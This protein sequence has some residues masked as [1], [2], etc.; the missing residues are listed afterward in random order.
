MREIASVC[1]DNNGFIWA[2][3]KTGILRLTED[4]YHVYQLPLETADILT[5][6][7]IYKNSRLFAYSNNGQLF[8]Y[9][10]LY[11]RFDFLFDIRKPLKDV[12]L[13]LH[14]IEIDGHGVFWLSVSSGLFKYQDGHL[15]PIIKDSDIFYLTWKDYDN[16]IYSQDDGIW[17]LNIRTLQNK[18][19]YKNTS[20]SPFQTLKLFYDR[21]TDLLW[22][23]TT[24]DGLFYY[25]FNTGIFSKTLIKT[26]PRQQIQAIECNSD[27]TL[28]FGIDGQGVWE[29]NRTG[30]R[31]LN[32]Y[33]EDVDDPS[34]L[35]GN[36]V[37]DIFCDS[38]KRVWVCT[39][40]GGLSFFEQTSPLVSQI[41]HEMNNSNS[42]NNN[43][44]NKIVEDREGNL[45]FATNNGVCRWDRLSEKWTTYYHN[46]QAQA[47][48]FLSLCEDDQGRI[49]AGAYSSGIYVIDEKTGKELAHY[50]KEEQNSAIKNDYVFDIV[51][52]REGNI[53]IGGVVGDIICYQTKENKFRTYSPQPVNAF[54]ELSDTTMLLACTYGLCLLNKRTGEEQILLEEYLS[55]D[56]LVVDSDAWICMS[57]GGLIRYDLDN[58]TTE[59][60]TVESGLPSN[61]VSSIL[62]EN[63][64]LWLS[65]EN[66]LCR[67][68]PK[69]KTTLI[70][71][72]LL[73]LSNVS[74]NRNSCCRLKNGQLAFGANTGAVLF[75]PFAIQ[76]VQ[77][78]GRIFF[79]DL[80]LS[81]RSV[82]DGSVLEL[83]APLDSLQKLALKYNQN[84]LTLEL[85]PIGTATA[86]S[87]FSWKMEGLD[88]EWS[89]PSNL[90]IL[91]YANLPIGKFALKIRLYDSSLSQLI[92]ERE[93]ALEI[94][95]PFWKTNWFRLFVFLL[96]AGIVYFSLRFYINRLKQRH[97]EDKVRFFTNTAHDIRTSLTLIK[98]PI[99]ELGKESQLSETGQ[100]YLHLA[101]E[102]ARRLSSVAT[103]LLD[104]EKTDIG[105]ERFSPRKTDMVKLITHR[106]LMFESFAKSKNITLIFTSGQTV[107]FTAVDETMME[108]VT[109]NLISN[110]VKYSH[111]DSQVNILFN[112]D[113]KNWTLEV[114]DHGI[115]ISKK[116]QSKLFREFYRS[117][118][119][120]NSKIVGSGIG[121]LL[122]KNYVVLHGG[123]ISCVSQENVGSTFKIVIPYKDAA[124]EKKPANRLNAIEPNSPV[125]NEPVVQT[126]VM[127]ENI[128]KREMRI[129]IVEDN[130]DLR[131]FMRHPL[132]EEFE[133]STAEDGVEAWKII[134][135]QMPDLVVSDV[136]MP[137]MDGFELC[138]LMKSTYE[139]SHIPLILLTAL[140]EKT[141]QLHGL[142]LGADDYLTK[143]F[144]MTL[145]SQR[146]KSIILNRKAVR[147]KALKLIRGNVDE[148]VFANELND[149][150]VKKAIETVR[151]NIANSEFGKDEFAFAMNVSPSVLYKKIKTLTDQSPVDFI[152]SIRL[153]QALELLQSRKYTVTEVSELCGFTSIS[154]FSQ[155]FRKYFGKSPTE[156]ADK[157]NI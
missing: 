71:S 7:L 121:L 123:N 126:S 132:G 115:G 26:F 38:N 22:I 28:L 81:G 48:V 16:L 52:D 145:L 65:T 139:T 105:K 59:K 91:S 30:D 87:K 143:P 6:K 8:S 44:V 11:D 104:F 144:D 74:F 67:F 137:N 50:S 55:S 58:R 19:I 47:Q 100:H 95:P 133:V 116:A 152:K 63:G 142:G 40:T 45:W 27:S 14:N 90:R 54:A 43:N 3:S 129:L 94:I 70:Y 21:R 107:Y 83:T 102:Q 57:G 33:K 154:Y 89:Q 148:P 93:I 32:V 2:S 86:G 73:P 149:N 92:A 72:S 9:N 15:S 60:F 78:Q 36:G 134:Q 17:T 39:Y 146:I 155:A 96:I 114:S 64:Y 34:S 136:M 141:E 80:S 131:D 69:D 41:S 61:Y 1:S 85:L 12:H 138:R 76:H 125:E 53:W 13:V 5:I 46:K 31:I 51:K 122:V 56:I 117:E 111:P 130:D 151:T 25:D 20:A 153:N 18:Q 97:T 82:R 109:D 103:Q 35:F 150:F 49:W 147:E 135:K 66:G 128:Q 120:V 10:T 29:L 124:E 99:E 110:A 98:A 118:N 4:D 88:T 24:S 127:Q 42:L 79:Q 113:S 140:T 112:G 84:T 68:N 106:K 119:A 23:G 77:S 108:K 157:S 156:Q 62:Y 101:T 37:Y 75:D